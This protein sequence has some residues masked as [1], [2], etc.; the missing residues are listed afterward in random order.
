MR[1]ILLNTKPLAIFRSK[2]EAVLSYKKKGGN[3][4]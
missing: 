2:G 3:D 1:V 4:I